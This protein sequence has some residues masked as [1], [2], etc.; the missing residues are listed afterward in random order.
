MEFLLL[1]KPIVVNN[2]LKPDVH[3]CSIIVK[4]CDSKKCSLRPMR[5]PPV[6]VHTEVTPTREEQ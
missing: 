2:L 4:Q 3:K 6:S 5:A 1:C